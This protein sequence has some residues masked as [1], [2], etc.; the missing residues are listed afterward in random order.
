VVE[1]EEE[2]LAVTLQEVLVVEDLV[3]LE[4]AQQC[5]EAQEQQTQ[6]RVVVETV[7]HSTTTLLPLEVVEL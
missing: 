2:K 7:G 5:Q 4:T 3:T 1:G 6:V